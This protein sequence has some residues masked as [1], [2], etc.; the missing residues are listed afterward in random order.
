ML[1]YILRGDA[2][3]W[4]GGVCNLCALAGP[5]CGRGATGQNRKKTAPN[6]GRARG[7][8]YATTGQSLPH[9]D[10]PDDGEIASTTKAQ[11]GAA[12][13]AQSDAAAKT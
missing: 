2:W 11:S 6:I 4:T 9:H 1:S 8:N 5:A 12:A 13:K 3:G 10:I 7:A